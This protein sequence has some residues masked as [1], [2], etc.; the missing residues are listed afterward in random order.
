MGMLYVIDNLISSDTPLY[1]SSIN[2]ADWVEIEH[3]YNKR[4]SKPFRFSGHG[5]PGNPEW[6]CVDLTESRQVT[7][8]GVFNHN[9]SLGGS[10]D[11][12]YIQGC[13]LTCRGQSGACNWDA[14][15]FE[16]SLMDRLVSRF[17][18]LYEVINATYR[19]FTL[20]ITDQN[21]SYPL[22]IGEWVL[23]L[24]E[25]FENARLQPYMSDGPMFTRTRSTTHYDQTWQQ[26]LS[27]AYTFSV[28]II[29]T[30]QSNQVDQLDYFLE[31]VHDNGGVF[32]FIPRSDLPF[33][34][35]VFIENEKD[36]ASQ[37][38][39]GRQRKGYAWKLN[40]KS[41]TEGISLL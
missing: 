35:Y 41:L 7:F 32:V 30:G 22:E 12:L 1:S 26:S 38:A 28:E 2:A 6:I 36:F 39:R 5:S 4:P 3:V 21:N 10:A 33:A 16:E 40:L 15:P 13:N 18:N 25:E 11:S 20:E 23:G 27:K 37:I 14:P 17:R 9:F 29:S 34:Y 24:A 31:R 19:Y 8:C